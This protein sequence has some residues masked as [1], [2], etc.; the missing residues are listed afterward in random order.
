M[1]KKITALVLALSIL[2]CSS[3]FAFSVDD[4]LPSKA[5]GGEGV[6]RAQLAESIVK[7]LNL[8]EIL[9]PW[10]ALYS[11]V[12]ENH[13]NASEITTLSEMKILSGYSDG[14]FRPEREV[15]NAE[16]IKVIVN[17]LGYDYKAK[18]YGGY[19]SGYIAV[20]NEL[21]LLSGVTGAYANPIN[22]DELKCLIENALDTPVAEMTGAGESIT[23]TVN[24]ENTL[25][26]KYHSMKK[27]TGVIRANP[28]IAVTGY[29][30]APEGYVNIDGVNYLCEDA[31]VYSMLGLT[32]D[33]VFKVDKEKGTFE[34]VE[35]EASEK[36]KV[37]EISMDDYEGFSGT[38]FKYEKNNKTEDVTID[39]LCDVFV[40]N[41]AKG[42]DAEVFDE[43]KSG[44]ITLIST[45]KNG[46][47]DLIIIK[48]YTDMVVGKIDEAGKR[49]Y[50]ADGSGEYIDSDDNGKK[51][52]IYDGT[53]KAVS[54]GFIAT[55][56]VI[57]YADGGSICEIYVSSSVVN[58]V[59]SSIEENE[60]G[61]YFTIGEEKV[62]LSYLAEES[63]KSFLPGQNIRIQLNFFG[64]GAKVKVLSKSGFEFVYL[65]RYGSR[66]GNAPETA[67]NV[68]YFHTE[69][70]VLTSEFASDLKLNDELI[71]TVTKA[72][73]DAKL[74]YDY[75]SLVGIKTDEKGI[76]THLITPGN[77][78][79]MEAEGK[80]G[81]VCTHPLAL[82]HRYT[83]PHRFNI[84]LQVTAQTPVLVIPDNP[85]LA[86]D[87]DYYLTKVDALPQG[88]IPVEAYNSTVDYG[89]PE[90]VIY[91]P[92]AGSAVA[93]AFKYESPVVAVKSIAKTL[94][95]NGAPAVKYTVQSGSKE[96]F[97]YYDGSNVSDTD[98]QT[99]TAYSISQVEVG[100]LIRFSADPSGYIRLLEVW[101]D[102]SKD[103]WMGN[104]SSIETGRGFIK[105]T[106]AKIVENYLY[107]PAWKGNEV[108]RYSGVILTEATL[109]IGGITVLTKREGMPPIVSAGT[110]ADVKK[111]D[112]IMIHMA[113]GQLIGI[114]LF[115]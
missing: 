37:I 88:D 104:P 99:L 26:Y 106:V 58:G 100:D 68:K 13:K 22:T 49:L 32:V 56:D 11:D 79:E 95:K 80:D 7:L 101:Y 40:N 103:E 69:K 102:A 59:L 82:R 48:S 10:K 108:D 29:F 84:A 94:D 46:R 73:L 66:V 54:F 76:I 55:G 74:G 44:S 72:K 47:Y 53:G 16:A 39:P 67:V 91:R 65:L 105:T 17:V 71:K 6:T 35:V 112:D 33:F 90:F 75:S 81:F 5:S 64:E 12:D 15:L 97:F 51:A 31:S 60:K 107:V 1:I 85:A 77:L 61:V 18:A 36:N 83:D 45:E 42:L 62:K 30:T 96:E 50:N 28:Y 57:T 19:P 27:E 114:V 111:Y 52:F 25:L 8:S 21:K 9:I 98:S 93:P 14:T 115:K 2:F 109:S 43:I 24:P 4:I 113:Y 70:G 34:I 78:A 110:S 87:D 20:A 63:F 89:I 92:A 41:S 86:S 38:T 3:V 23:Y